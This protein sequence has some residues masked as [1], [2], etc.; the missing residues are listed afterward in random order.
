M[1]IILPWGCS[2]PSCCSSPLL[3]LHSATPAICTFSELLGPWV[4]QVGHLVSQHGINCSVMGPP[5]KNAV[6]KLDTAYDDLGNTDHFNI[7]YSQGFEI[8]L[9]DYKSFAFSKFCSFQ[10]GF[11]L[12]EPIFLYTL[13]ILGNT[14]IFLESE[15]F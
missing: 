2:L 10:C 1:I 3:A 5:E 4:L 14:L 8:V 9:N 7:I 6:E 15:Y 12:Q 11:F 13:W